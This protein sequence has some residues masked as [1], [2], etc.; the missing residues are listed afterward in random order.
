M[1]HHHAHHLGHCPAY[2]IEGGSLLGLT[3]WVSPPRVTQT[4]VTPLLWPWHLC[5]LWRLLVCNVSPDRVVGD[6][7]GP[8]LPALV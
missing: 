5:L 4:L 8:V 3:C 2:C 7:V 1:V 6:S